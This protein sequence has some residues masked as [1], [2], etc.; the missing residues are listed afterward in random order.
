MHAGI[1]RSA[2]SLTTGSFVFKMMA[3]YIPL[4]C[5]ADLD[6]TIFLPVGSAMCLFLS[7]NIF[8]HSVLK[9]NFPAWA[10]SWQE[11]LCAFGTHPS[12]SAPSLLVTLLFEWS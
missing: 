1:I 6:Q 9:G 11:F 12:Y 7:G 5:V 4:W 8:V 3:S 2:T 10:Y